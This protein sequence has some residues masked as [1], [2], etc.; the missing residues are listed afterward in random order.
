MKDFCHECGKLEEEDILICKVQCVNE[1]DS[2]E[3]TL[4]YHG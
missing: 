2:I 3:R 4:K 1:G